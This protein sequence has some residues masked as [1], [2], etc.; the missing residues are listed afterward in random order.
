VFMGRN[1]PWIK[2]N[3]F[4]VGV[5]AERT[6]QGF[7]RSILN[8]ISDLVP[9]DT[10][11][12][13]FE[14]GPTRPVKLCDNLGVPAKWVTAH[15]NYYYKTAPA[16]A[17]LNVKKAT[18]SNY[19]LF[20]HTEYYQD[21]LHP[22]GVRYGAG[23]ILHDLRGKTALALCLTDSKYNYGK[24]RRVASLLETIQPHLENYYSSLNL[25]SK[26]SIDEFYLAELQE[27][28]KTLSKREAEVAG[29]LC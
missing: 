17:D 13:W 22:L 11:V 5:G 28:C 9:Y 14:M 21:F 3:D 4:L 29:L 18:F 19:K 24:D 25:I 7:C 15:N 1:L 10:S 27:G 2:I 23:I 16:H 12:A 8:Q 20:Q 26:Q 6:V